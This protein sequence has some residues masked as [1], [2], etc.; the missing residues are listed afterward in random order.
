MNEGPKPL[1]RL[2]R[3]AR[4]WLHLPETEGR[5]A[6]QGERLAALEAEFHDQMTMVG[7]DVHLK[8][9]AQTTVVFVSRLGQGGNGTVKIINLELKDLA[10]LREIM[11]HLD[12]LYGQRL[13]LDAGPFVRGGLLK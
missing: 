9:R 10:E 3:R 13:A 2:A 7:V 4:S 8:P 1:S 6:R 5:I 11:Q 12:R